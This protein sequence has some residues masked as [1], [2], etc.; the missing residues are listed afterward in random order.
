MKKILMITILVTAIFGVGGA[1]AG[2][3]SSCHFHGNKVATEETVIKCASD[4]KEVLIKQGKID[5]SWKTI[6]QDKIEMVEGKKGK[7]WLVTFTNPA[8]DDKAKEKLYLFFTST[9]N[10]IAANFTGN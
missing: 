1:M 4:R 5:P 3:D 8:V 6:K 7:E 2:E 9:G 10:F